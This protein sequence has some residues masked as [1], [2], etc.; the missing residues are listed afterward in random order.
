MAVFA[1]TSSEVFYM[2]ASLALSGICYY[3]YRKKRTNVEQLHRAPHPPIDKNLKT[4]MKATPGESLQY[5]A[6]E[7]KVKSVGEPLRS[8][9]NNNTLGVLRRLILY[10]SRHQ[11]IILSHSWKD[12]RPVIHE[13]PSMVP[14]VLV[15]SDKTIV[16]VQDPLQASGDYMEKIH[17]RFYD[18]DDI[19]KYNINGVKPT[20]VLEMEKM[21]KVG[22]SLT[23]VGELIMETDGTL[24]L[25]PPTNGAQYLLS[26]GDL[27]SVK[28]RAL[29]STVWW[30]FG[31]GVCAL[32]GGAGLSRM[33]FHYCRHLNAVWR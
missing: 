30:R 14:F 33:G 12:N 21:L 26:R 22:T 17:H 2:G 13:R 18:L 29:S 5:A 1:V 24:S 23:G 7:G 27:S 6:I 31:F 32:A 28:Q 16:R 10:I 9:F 15:G 25:R 4:L 11:Q 8:Q 20:R 3:M 19:I